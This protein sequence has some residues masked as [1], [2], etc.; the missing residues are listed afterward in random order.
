MRVEEE[1][2]KYGFSHES[3]CDGLDLLV[4]TD[5]SESSRTRVDR[6]SSVH[7]FKASWPYLFPK[8]QLSQRME[9]KAFSSMGSSWVLLLVLRFTQQVAV[10]FRPHLHGRQLL[11]S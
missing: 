1:D 10:N 4:G 2:N 3:S 5:R 6:K 9:T 11:F 7:F 8:P